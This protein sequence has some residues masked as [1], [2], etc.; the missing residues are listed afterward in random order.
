MHRERTVK[1]TTITS[2]LFVAVALVACGGSGNSAPTTASTGSSAPTPTTGSQQGTT[3][4]NG[5]TVATSV[6]TGS[7][8]AATTV[9]GTPIMPLTGQAIKDPALA[10][11][12]ALVVKIDNFP[13]ARPQ[14]GLNRADIVFEENVE[15]ITRFAAVFQSQ[16]P[17]PVGPIRSGREQDVQLLGSL[18]KPIFAWS[19]GNPGVTA[20]IDGSDFVVANV[21]TNA[22]QASKSYRSK[23]RAVPHNLYAQGSGLF[24]MAPAG[25]TPPPPQFQYLKSGDKAAGAAS[26]GADV[27]MDG[28]KVRWTYEAKSGTYLRFQGGKAHNDA[29]LGQVNSTNVVVLVVDYVQSKIYAPS[30]IAQTLGTGEAYLFT[31]GKVVHGTWTRKDRLDTFTLKADDGTPMLLTPGRTWVELA[32]VKTTTPSPA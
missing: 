15:Q 22:R 6:G 29:A 24:T 17:D 27:Q 16:N 4:G 30:P 2:M 12:P 10:A 25:A 8:A 7:T 20:A 19:G 26:S 32:R 1:T 3:I 11:R 31:G 13:D 5:T 28:V 18:N 21:Q 9:P 14:S 23:D